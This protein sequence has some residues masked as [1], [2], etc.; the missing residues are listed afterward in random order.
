MPRCLRRKAYQHAA[1][2]TPSPFQRSLAE[3]GESANRDPQAAYAAC[4]DL[5]NKTTQAVEVQ[6]LAG[7]FTNLG[8]ILNK[9]DETATTLASWREH[10]AVAEDEDITASLYRAESVV[11]TVNDNED[12]AKACAQ[13]GVR[14][15]SEQCRMAIMTA[16]TFLAR[17]QAARSLPLLKQ[18]A[19]LCQELGKDDLIL[20]QAAAIADNITMIAQNQLRAAQDLLLH[21]SCRP[22]RALG[23]RSATGSAPRFIHLRQSPIIMRR[24]VSGTRHRAKNDGAGNLRCHRQHSANIH[25]LFGG[26]R[27]N[28]TRPEKNR[29]TGVCALPRISKRR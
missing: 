29:Q 21:A 7:L 4:S 9:C 27:T 23:E 12:E 19:N 5:Y 15:A 3:L 11:H 20:P 8:C 22:R 13:K 2:V 10:P 6:Q 1:M 26:T 28:G 16:Q 17:Q 24:S 25:R 14:N 18:C